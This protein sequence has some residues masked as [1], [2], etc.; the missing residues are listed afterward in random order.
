ML[1]CSALIPISI[2]VTFKVS[3]IE[4]P[5]IFGGGNTLY[6]GGSGPGN[7]S[8]I[9][10]A[11][12]VAE[13]GDTVFVFN[14]TY[15]EYVFIKKSIQLSGENK[16]T[17]IIDAKGL[18]DVIKVEEDGTVI[19]GF[20]IRNS[21][22]DEAGVDFH[23]KHNRLSDSIIVDNDYG[24]FMDW[25]GYNTI[26]NCTISYND[27][28]IQDWDGHNTISNNNINSNT[29]G[30]ILMWCINNTVSRNNIAHNG[31]CIGIDFSGW[32]HIIIDNTLV[33]NG[34]FAVGCT[35]NTVVNNTINGKSLVFL[36]KASDI[37]VT[38][39]GQVILIYCDN[40][41]VQNIV[42]SHLQVGIELYRTTRCQIVENTINNCTRFALLLQNSQDNI[43]ESNTIMNNRQGI[44]LDNSN[45][46]LIK[47]NIIESNK[48]VGIYVG[49]SYS[50]TISEN[51]IR[52]NDEGIHLRY[53]RTNVLSDNLISNNR[54][55]GV[56]LSSSKSDVITGN[57]VSSNCVSLYSSFWNILQRNTIY[58]LFLGTSKL[59]MIIRNNLLVHKDDI[60]FENALFNYWNR[61]YW[62]K[63]LFLPRKIKGNYCYGNWPNIRYI[64]VYNFDWR[65]AREPYDI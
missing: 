49:Y 39:A 31:N 40:I 10:D 57:Y 11:I 15:F 14:G 35:G 23:S 55:Y 24:I 53:D 29:Q 20:T 34:F 2:G 62:N 5:S 46:N 47:K 6:V 44:E 48:N 50:N 45:R 9:Q 18:N 4:Q 17:T 58:E 27:I 41:T 30:G 32:D 1:I 19:R 65:P 61:N 33:N 38:N 26:S 56:L 22:H 12:N 54:Y 43:I 42:L 63:P 60:L 21:G 59:N 64:T 7:Y 16:T 13:D 52:S 3:K 28:G 51:F 36:E 25:G 8:R 37:I